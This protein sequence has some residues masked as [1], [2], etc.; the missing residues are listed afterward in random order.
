MRDYDEEAFASQLAFGHGVRR[1]NRH[2][3]LDTAL[4][5]FSPGGLAVPSAVEAG[6]SI[7][8]GRFRA[9]WPGSSAG[10]S[11]K[12]HTWL[13]YNPNQPLRV[14]RVIVQ[15]PTWPGKVDGRRI[16]LWAHLAQHCL[17]L[18]RRRVLRTAEI[19]IWGEASGPF[20]NDVPPS[21]AHMPSQTVY[22]TWHLTLSCPW[23]RSG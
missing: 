21:P 22:T 3:N 15:G 13:M 4:W 17:F 9:G 1:S 12:A 2:S 10:R 19:Y 5:L 7:G 14:P 16:V 8:N 11:T 23:V 18:A 6:Y 20:Q